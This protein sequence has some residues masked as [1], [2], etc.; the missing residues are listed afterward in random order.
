MRKAKERYGEYFFEPG[1][2]M[3]HDTS[4]HRIKIGDKIVKA[5]CASLLFAFSRKLFFQYYARFT[6]FEAKAFL[7]A[8]LEYMDGSCKRCVIDNTSVILASGS[9]AIFSPEMVNFARMFG[10]TFF[11]H[12][13]QTLLHC[14]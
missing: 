1:E 9:D 2:E 7:L 4:P 12:A 5:Q 14:Y 11:A 13:I 6:R 3:Q 10:F 8:A